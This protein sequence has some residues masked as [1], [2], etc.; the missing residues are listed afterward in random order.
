MKWSKTDFENVIKKRLD[1]LDNRISPVITTFLSNKKEYQ[2]VRWNEILVVIESAIAERGI[3]RTAL[4][5][6][7]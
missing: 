4:I 3:L 2:K 1:E 5:Y 7:L 6:R